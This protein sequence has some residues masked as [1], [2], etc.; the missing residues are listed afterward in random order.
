MDKNRPPKFV[1][2]QY[3]VSKKFQFRYI[4][5]I[6]ALMFATAALCSYVVYYNSLVLLGEKLANVYPQGRLVAILKT[7]NLR[8]LVSVILISPLVAFLGVILSHRIA[9]P[10]SRMERFLNEVAAG[11]LS[12]RLTLR[13][14]DELIPLADGINNVVETIK[15]N[16]DMHRSLFKTGSKI[17]KSHDTQIRAAQEE[18]EKIGKVLWEKSNGPPR[19]EILTA[20]DDKKEKP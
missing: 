14:K 12:K 2:K 10:I 1:R 16:V 9:G 11:D 17:M 18:I 8:V 13:P 7:V 15:N 19:V 6:L 20:E 5:V 3:I 4:G